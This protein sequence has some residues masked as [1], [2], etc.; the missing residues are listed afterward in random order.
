[1]EVIN[2]NNSPD[3]RGCTPDELVKGLERLEGDTTSKITPQNTE[4]IKQWCVAAL[5][6]GTS[7][8]SKLAINITPITTHNPRF[9]L[10]RRE[11]VVSLLGEMTLPTAAA[12]SPPASQAS[13]MDQQ[14]DRM[15]KIIES[16]MKAL[17]AMA[18]NQNPSQQQQQH[19]QQQQQSQQS[20][21]SNPLNGIKPLEGSLLAAVMGWSGVIDKDDVKKIWLS[22]MSSKPL[23]D[24]RDDITQEVVEWGKENGYPVN[25][26]F[27]LDK[28]FFTDM[29]T[30]DL[31]KG[32]A[33]ASENQIN[34]GFTPQWTIE[35]TLEYKQKKIEEERAE[36]ETENTRTLEEKLSLTKVMSRNPPETLEELKLNTATFTGLT[37]VCLGEGSDLYQK[38]LGVCATVHSPAVRQMKNL[39][40]PLKIKQYHFGLVDGCR[41]F[42]YQRVK[43]SEFENGSIPRFPKS[44]LH[45]LI[46]FIQDGRPYE[47]IS[48]P[49]KWLASSSAPPAGLQQWQYQAPPSN[50]HLAPPQAKR[51]RFG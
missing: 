44:S 13:A 50:E 33:R 12:P 34:R 43:P 30:G 15:G 17:E 11:K 32:E 26:D 46:P 20:Q 37:Y 42:F 29:M 38:V 8:S 49:R 47:N 2:K 7:N 4:F 45:I 22:L 36:D 3:F 6:T 48:F 25:E 39:L 23:M 14:L 5:T 28:T 35:T 18:R 40:T 21:A 9:V 1:M 19:Q 31:A 27:F 24:K 16:S 41:K 51:V 10:F